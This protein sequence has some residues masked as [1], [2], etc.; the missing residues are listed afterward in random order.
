MYNKLREDLEDIFEYWESDVC[1]DDVSDLSKEKL[2]DVLEQSDSFKLYRYMPTEYFNIRNIETQTI[3]LSSNGVMND[4]FEGLPETN[5]EMT[6]TQLKQLGNL[7]YMVCLTESN[8][9][10]LMWSHYAR[11]HEGICVEYDLKLLKDD[12]HR[13]IEHTFPVVYRRNRH[14]LR[15]IESLITSHNDLCISIRDEI[16]YCGT[17]RL[18][19]ILPMFLCKSKEWE[20]EKEWRI[21]YTLKQMYEINSQELY[22]CN[23]GFSCISAVYLG[24]RI[25]PEIR[26]N[27]LE[28]CERNSKDSFRISVYQAKLS[29]LTYEILF[30]KI[31]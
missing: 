21:L 16:D 10:L 19:D 20:Y 28:I 22:A 7:A 26:K 3:H 2:K 5:N 14:Y 1:D 31:F 24:C 13:I 30:D 12:P 23:L 6:A 25:H 15:D 9:N 4:A 17:E 18:D 11:N 27:I 29:N 8:N